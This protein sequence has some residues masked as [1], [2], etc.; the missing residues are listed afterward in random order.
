MPVL[1]RISMDHRTRD[2]RGIEDSLEIIKELEKEGVDAFDVDAG[3]YETID[4]IFP[5]AYLGDAVWHIQHGPQKKRC[6]FQF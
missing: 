3:S 6:Q 4:Y 1:F 5:T 2:G